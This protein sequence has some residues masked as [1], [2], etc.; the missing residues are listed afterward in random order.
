MVMLA[1]VLGSHA[2]GQLCAAVRICSAEFW[3]L[4]VDRSVLQPAALIL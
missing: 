3:V 2:T 1:F 4:L